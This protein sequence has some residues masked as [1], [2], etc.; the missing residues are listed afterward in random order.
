MSKF[1]DAYQVRYLK[2][3]PAAPLWSIHSTVIR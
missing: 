2:K 1:V 3:C